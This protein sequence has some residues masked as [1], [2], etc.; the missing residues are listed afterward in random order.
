MMIAYLLSSDSSI[1][2]AE[3][4]NIWLYILFLPVIMYWCGYVLY[5]LVYFYQYRLE[6]YIILAFWKTGIGYKLFGRPPRWE[7]INAKV[8]N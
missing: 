2:A 5:L 6:R 7:R 1:R 8:T 4:D 3:R